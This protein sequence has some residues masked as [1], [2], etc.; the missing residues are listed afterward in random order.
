[1]IVKAILEASQMAKIPR[2]DD[3]P[4]TTNVNSMSPTT[5]AIHELLAITPPRKKQTRLLLSKKL[6]KSL[7]ADRLR[8][9]ADLISKAFHAAKTGDQRTVYS[10]VKTLTGTGVRKTKFKQP[11]LDAKGAPI[12]TWDEQATH[13]GNWLKAKFEPST[14]ERERTMPTLKPLQLIPGTDGR[15][16]YEDMPA[17]E[18]ILAVLDSFQEDTATGVD[19]IQGSVFRHSAPLRA[20]M[21]GLI[22][23]IWVTETV[24]RK[25]SEAEV[26]FLFKNKGS[27]NDRAAYR[28]IS[29]LTAAYKSFTKILML[30]LT[31]TIDGHLSKSWQRRIQIY[32]DKDST[33]QNVSP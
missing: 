17:T 32:R 2:R 12:L 31:A 3:G 5:L 16:P 8:W 27:I 9:Q 21:V 26:F 10:V 15:D 14:A 25:M 30:Q 20:A 4:R 6:K 24:P 13:W 1:M 29:L 11:T 23:D 33:P 7:A 19:H 18:M 28:P 22:Q